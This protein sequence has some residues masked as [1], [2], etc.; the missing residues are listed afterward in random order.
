MRLD[1]RTIDGILQID[2]RER[3]VF[4]RAGSI[5]AWMICEVTERDASFVDQH[6][7]ELPR[8]LLTDRLFEMCCRHSR[9]SCVFCIGR[10]LA[11]DHCRLCRRET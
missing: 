2:E 10:A 7:S 11:E 9:V 4:R 8:L 5:S 1:D 3:V 6:V